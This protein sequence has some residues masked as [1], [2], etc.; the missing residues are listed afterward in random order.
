MT[1]RPD[2]NPQMASP[3]PSSVAGEIRSTVPD[4]DD[5]KLAAMMCQRIRRACLHP[6]LVHWEVAERLESSEIVFVRI[7]WGIRVPC[8]SNSRIWR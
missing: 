8:W 4:V 5:G 6:V 3:S 2:E 1:D 7:E